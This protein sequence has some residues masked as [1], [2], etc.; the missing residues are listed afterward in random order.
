MNYVLICASKMQTNSCISLKTFAPFGGKFMYR[1]TEKQLQFVEFDLPFGGELLASNRWVRLSQMVPWHEFEN[2]Y[3]TNLSNS[4][5]GPPAFS[6]RMALAALI[7]KERLGLSDEESVEQ[8]TENPYLQYFCGLK[9]FTTKAPFHPTMYVH[10]RK[11]F[12]VD[13]L[14][15]LN[16]VIVKKAVKNTRKD[17]DKGPGKGV[18]KRGGK[19]EEPEPDK[20][21]Q[22]KLLMDATCVPADITFPT[23]LKLLNTAREKTEAIIDILHKSRGKGHKKPRTYRIKARKAWLAIAKSKKIRKAKLRKSLRSQLCFINRNLKSIG[24][25]SKVVPLTVLGRRQYR[26]LLVI[27]E[28][29]RQQQWMYDHRSKRIDNRIV[30]ISQPHVRP[31]KRGKAGSDTEFGAKLSVSLVDGFAFVDRTSWDNFNESGDLQGQVEAFKRRYGFYPESVHADKIYRSRGNR[32]YCKSKGIRLSGPRL[33]RPPKVTP[34]NVDRLKAEAKQARQDEIDRI[35]IEGK[36]GQGKRKYGI[37]RLMTKLA[38]TSETAISLCFLVMNLE[39]WLAAIFLRLFFKEQIW[40]FEPKIY[41]L[42]VPRRI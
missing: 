36:F 9:Q 5:Q 10:F 41:T 15:D 27:N 14:N 24:K 40:M 4:G 11:R 39:R 31:I 3:C 23:D 26:D 34:E 35:P 22:G 37:G 30:S 19:E 32:R 12:P 25:L 7:I 29:Y 1:R 17:N 6:V 38:E 13:V 21:N 28:L 8:I 42:M 18:G 20:T 2:D 16:E 33:G